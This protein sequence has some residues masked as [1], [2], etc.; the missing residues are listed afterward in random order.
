MAVL[1]VS[2]AAWNGVLMT[3]QSPTRTQAHTWAYTHANLLVDGKDCQ[4]G[5][6]PH[7]SMP[8]LKTSPNGWH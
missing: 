3:E 2:I 1:C 4:D 8:V 6:P 5:I 7:V